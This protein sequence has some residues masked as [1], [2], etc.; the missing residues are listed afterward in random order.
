[1]SLSEE[2]IDNISRRIVFCASA[3]Q[4]HYATG[5]IFN[6]KQ[7]IDKVSG[8]SRL[9]EK[10]D[11]VQ[12]QLKIFLSTWGAMGSSVRGNLQDQTMMH[13]FVNRVC[14][15]VED[16]RKE[17]ISAFDIDQ[18][19]PRII[20]FLDATIKDYSGVSTTTLT[21]FMHLCCPYL[22]VPMDIPVSEW[23]GKVCEEGSAGGVYV[24]YLKDVKKILARALPKVKRDV[25]VLPGFAVSNVY[26]A[27]KFFWFTITKVYDTLY[28]MVKRIV[29]IAS[30]DALTSVFK[31]MFKE[32]KPYFEKIEKGE[33][34]RMLKR[35]GQF[36][37]VADII[38]RTG[39]Q[40]A[41]RWAREFSDVITKIHNILMKK[42]TEWRSSTNEI[43]WLMDH[44]LSVLQFE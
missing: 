19:A 40:D 33:I 6:Y 34:E 44:A 31:E 26:F 25:E 10:E 42:E 9:S 3:I 12:E 13:D 18:W 24:S 4:K 43:T 41:P 28:S 37:P 1:M 15:F 21:K 32:K 29:F 7:P 20:N 35:Y 39:Q 36:M 17:T 5:D 8:F 22:F 23:Y 11:D 14:S 27:D 16:H 2:L 38:C 30:H